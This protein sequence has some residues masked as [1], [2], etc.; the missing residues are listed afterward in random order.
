MELHTE[1]EQ[2]LA[3][4]EALARDRGVGLAQSVVATVSGDRLMIQ[5]ALSNLLSSAIRLTPAGREV[6]VAVAEDVESATV[7]VTNP[8]PEIP[9][10]HLSRIFERSYRIDPSRREVE[11]DHAGL[12]LAIARSIVEMHGGGIRAESS[13]GETCFIVTLPRGHTVRAAPLRAVRS[14]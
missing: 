5:R 12:G 7:S 13:A 10:R 4:Y 2:L 8:G 6:A 14:V 9:A 11:A 1:V 3:F